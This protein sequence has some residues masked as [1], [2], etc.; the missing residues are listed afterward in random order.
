MEIFVGLLILGV[1]AAAITAANRYA[2]GINDAWA[3][4]AARLGL[5]FQ[6][7]STFKRRAIRGSRGAIRVELNEKNSGNNNT[8]RE[9]RLAYPSTPFSMTLT[10]ET[11]GK[12]LLKAF[13][14]EDFEVGDSTFDSR[15]MIAGSDQVAISRY[16]DT[17]R[18][19]LLLEAADKLPGLKVT[20]SDI[21]WRTS[22]QYKTS[23]ALLDDAKVLLRTA[24]AMA[25]ETELPAP[26]SRPPLPP[27]R[28]PF[29]PAEPAPARAVAQSAPLETDRDHLSGDDPWVASHELPD[30]AEPEPPEEPRVRD[31]Q[32]PAPE[33]SSEPE[34]VASPLSGNEL[35]RL[36]DLIEEVLATR[37]LSFE[38]NQ[39]VADKY[40]GRTLMVLGSVRVVRKESRDFDFRKQGPGVRI[41]AVV[42][43]VTGT[44]VGA[45]EV[46]AIAYLEGAI[47]PP[48]RGSEVLITGTILK[49]EALRRAIYLVDAQLG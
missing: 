16:L 12:K 39:I 43:E 48:A 49:V 42:G 1:V 26:P 36:D 19:R 22:N 8:V 14:A 3:D 20:N 15:F 10:L 40:A 46:I 31:E 11:P 17:E 28:L 21:T 41:E 30:I 9:W 5:D 25:T 23:P 7:G 27:T 35:V 34:V 33:D 47:V 13:G 2:K 6:P 29:R 38:A 32:S 37:R 44:R 24:A 18:R 45:G 4:A